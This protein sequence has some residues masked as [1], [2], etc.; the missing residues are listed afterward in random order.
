MTSKSYTPFGEQIGEALSGFAYNGEYYNANTGM[1]YLRARFYEPEMNRFSQKDILW[2]DITV[3]NSLNSYA[4]VQNDP[5]NYCDP[6]GMRQ[7]KGIDASGTSGSIHSVKKSTTSAAAVMSARAGS[8]AYMYSNEARMNGSAAAAKKAQQA[9]QQSYSY[10]NEA[11][12]NGNGS[13]V[14]KTYGALQAVEKQANHVYDKT[15]YVAANTTPEVE[16]GGNTKSSCETKDSGNLLLEILGIANTAIGQSSGSLLT[17][18]SKKDL[19]AKHLTAAGK[20][21][22]LKLK[23]FG[24]IGIPIIGAAVDMGLQLLS[25]EAAHHALIKTGAHL[26]IGLAAAAIFTGGGWIALTGAAVTVLATTGF[27]MLY[28]SKK[29]F[30]DEK[31][32]NPIKAKVDEHIVQPLKNTAL[33]I[34]DKFGEMF[35]GRNE[36]EAFA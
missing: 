24:S 25:G 23:K 21:H 22:A 19:D 18:I 30:I 35:S 34:A 31:I 7:V 13:S 32:Y 4:Y 26:V 15:P 5:V 16:R 8:M 6:S 28:D 33:R 17:Y 9:I 20:S 2:G 1:I 3:P 10:A 14:Y 12:M 29:A 11:R 27:D 36:N